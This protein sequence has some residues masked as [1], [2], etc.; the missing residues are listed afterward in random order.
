MKMNKS[1]VLIVALFLLI[2]FFYFY[3]LNQLPLTAY[4]EATYGQVIDATLTSGQAT[5]LYRLDQPWFEKPPLYFWLAMGSVQSFGHQEWVYRLPSVMLTMLAFI[6]FYLLIVELS[7]NKKLAIIS[8]VTLSLMPYFYITARE[9][10]LDMPLIA[11]ILASLYFF[12]LAWRRPNF[13]YLVF[14]TLALGLMMKSVVALVAVF[15]YLAFSFFY[16]QWSWLKNKKLW[17]GLIPALV[18]L[19]PWHIQMN[20]LWGQ[21]FWQDYLGYH[22]YTRAVKGFGDTNFWYYLKNFWLIG[23]LWWWIFVASFAALL[24]KFIKNKSELSPL[25]KAS[26]LCFLVDLVIFSLAKTHINTYILPAYPFMALIMAWF[27]LTLW[28]F[29]SKKYLK[30]IFIIIFLYISVNLAL[31]CLGI[32]PSVRDTLHPWFDFHLRD[33][34]T[35]IKNNTAPA[36]IY[37]LD[38]PQGDT[39]SFYSGRSV[40][41]V[42]RS[43]LGQGY[44]I[45]GPAYILL[46]DYSLNFFS[47]QNKK[48]KLEYEHLKVAYSRDHLI[49]LYSDKSFSLSGEASQ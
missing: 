4:D 14:P 20:N 10:R 5:I 23:Q 6:F 39:L 18:I 21:A 30:I 13:Y 46:T 27:L 33:M 1:Q 8:V 16:H 48:I 26:A 34:A 40:K 24:I 43:L 32:V 25:A 9:V 22:I 2:G 7:K 42:D 15:F 19:L 29:L 49:L 41:V 45:E 38:G 44:N 31:F 37:Q 17:L 3:Q 11:F 28:E 36:N 12:V 35:V 47:G